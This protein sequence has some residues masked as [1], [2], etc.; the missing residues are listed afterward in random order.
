MFLNLSWR[1][2]YIKDKQDDARGA[3]LWLI[4]RY[5]ALSRLLI[6]Q[7]PFSKSRSAPVYKGGNQVCQVDESNPI[8]GKCACHILLLLLNWTEPLE[9]Q[10]QSGNLSYNPFFIHNF[11][12][13]SNIQNMLMH[14][15]C[16]HKMSDFLQ[17]NLP[18]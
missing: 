3:N 10:Y 8:R 6:Y 18:S 13:K 7:Q 14:M 12:S 1:W 5:N 2:Y 15:S 9:D 17:T 11:L 16:T 4:C